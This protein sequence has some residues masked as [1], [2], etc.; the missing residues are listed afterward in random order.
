MN[1]RTA[2]LLSILLL[3]PIAG[4]SADQAYTWID[5]NGTTHFSEEP[6]LDEAI[7][8]E[9]IDL[10]PAPSAG[11]ID[12]DNDFYSVVNQADRM[13]RKRLENEKLTAER[14]QTEI[15]AATETSEAQTTSQTPDQKDTQEYTRFYPGYPK[16]MYNGQRHPHNNKPH[17]EKPVEPEQLPARKP[18]TSIG[19]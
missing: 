18:G 17:P 3:L 10:L 7:P 8:A 1:V 13:E 19:N 9:K 5:E 11:N 16:Q 14:L 4:F 15:E 2:R 6:P 12:A